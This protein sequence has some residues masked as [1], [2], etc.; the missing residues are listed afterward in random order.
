MQVITL[1]SGQVRTWE[2]P[3]AA[4]R[5]SLAGQGAWTGNGRTLLVGEEPGTS[6]LPARPQAA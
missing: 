5:P 6:F 3:A 2:Q 4:W 1:G